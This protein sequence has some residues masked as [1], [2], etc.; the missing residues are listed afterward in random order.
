MLRPVSAAFAALILVLAFAAVAA[1]P[2]RASQRN[3]N[4]AVMLRLIDQTRAERA[5]AP[6]HVRGAPAGSMRRA[7]AAPGPSARRSPGA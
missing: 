3:D 4:E 2:V 6:L 5:L 7:A 1:G